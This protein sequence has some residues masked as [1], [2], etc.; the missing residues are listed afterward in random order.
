[1]SSLKAVRHQIALQLPSEVYT[2]AVAADRAASSDN[3]K[4][5]IDLVD[6]IYCILDWTYSPEAD[7]E[8]HRTVAPFSLLQ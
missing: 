1:M 7:Q 4:A 8:L 3:R 2:L 5:C 6:R